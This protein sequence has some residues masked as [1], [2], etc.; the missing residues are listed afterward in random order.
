VSIESSEFL[1]FS[2]HSPSLIYIF[3]SRFHSLLLLFHPPPHVLRHYIK[4][5]SPTPNSPF[6]IS[7]SSLISITH[8]SL[9]Q[10]HLKALFSLSLSHWS[11]L[12]IHKRRHKKFISI[13]EY[14]IARGKSYVS[15]FI[16]IPVLCGSK[17]LRSFSF[18]IESWGCSGNLKISK[19]NKLC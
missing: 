17:N 9:I 16:H 11:T 19:R 15:T 6:T 10:I 2:I 13:C 5:Y 18:L 7:L 12:T 3:L 14:H 4:T 1:Y 8:I